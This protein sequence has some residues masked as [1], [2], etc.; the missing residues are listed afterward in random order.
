MALLSFFMKLYVYDKMIYD[1]MPVRIPSAIL[2]V[3]VMSRM[4]RNAGIASRLN[5]SLIWRTTPKR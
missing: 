5:V 1:M 3:I 4:V 2:P